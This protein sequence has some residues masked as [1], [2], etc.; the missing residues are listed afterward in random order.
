M[1]Q[2][3]FP[4]AAT[5]GDHDSPMEGKKQKEISK[6]VQVKKYHIVFLEKMLHVHSRWN[7]IDQDIFSPSVVNVCMSSEKQFL[8]CCGNTY[9]TITHSIFEATLGGTPRVGLFCLVFH[10][11]C[12]ISQPIKRRLV[13]G[14]FLA[15][16][17]HY[18]LPTNPYPSP[19]RCIHSHPVYMSMVG[20]YTQ[21]LSNYHTVKE[22]ITMQ[23]HI[24]KAPLCLLPSPPPLFPVLHSSIC[25]PEISI[26]PQ[27]N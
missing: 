19:S 20:E 16:L 1:L 15:C 25:S 21:T 7:I 23:P 4:S 9:S 14:T 12:L 18:S 26:R 3:I 5:I 11:G 27:V 24:S 8:L 10:P 13:K 17:T 2:I 22:T 6:N